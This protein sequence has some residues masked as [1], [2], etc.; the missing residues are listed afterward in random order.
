MADELLRALGKR[1]A[2]SAPGRAGDEAEGSEAARAMLRRFD[3]DERAELLD[4][5]FA[6]LDAHAEAPGTQSAA[7]PAV[8]VLEARR[9]PRAAWI[10]AV[11]AIA[12]VLVLWLGTTRG[13]ATSGEAMPSY[14]A[15]RLEGGTAT[16]RSAQTELPSALELAPDASIDWIFTPATPVRTPVAAVILA[17]RVGKTPVLVR[18]AALDV[19]AQGVVRIKGSLGEVL[20]LSPGTWSLDVLLG[21]PTRLPDS[22]AAAE[23]GGAWS[24]VSFEVKIA[25]PR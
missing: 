2:D 10:G 16:M 24:R 4:G 17:A 5:V 8:V 13:P 11:V 3:A 18:P 6:E 12:A 19:S 1:Q 23:Q 15:T 22:V 25:D 21:E 9:R 20:P 14:A 7:P